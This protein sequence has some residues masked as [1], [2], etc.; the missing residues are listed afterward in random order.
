MEEQNT[1]PKRQSV[2]AVASPA[3]LAP[4][5]EEEFLQPQD[6]VMELPTPTSSS[7]SGGPPPQKPKRDGK[8]VTVASPP[9]LAPAEEEEVLVPLDG[10]LEL[11]VP[12]TLPVVSRAVGNQKVW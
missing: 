4:A 9:V 1:V 6:G 7:S 12:R 3:V 8:K 5:K 2:V 11:P 10:V